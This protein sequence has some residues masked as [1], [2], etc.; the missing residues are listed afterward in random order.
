MLQPTPQLQTSPEQHSTT[1]NAQRRSV[2]YCVLQVQRQQQVIK[3]MSQY[4]SFHQLQQQA[5]SV[6][7]Q[8]QQQT[9][10]FGLLL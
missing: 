10:I 6:T 2:I 8:A 5:V 3:L 1:E 9:Q 7:G 4:L